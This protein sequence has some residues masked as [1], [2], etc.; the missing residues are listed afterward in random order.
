M[1]SVRIT[2]QTSLLRVEWVKGGREPR[3]LFEKWNSFSRI[4]VQR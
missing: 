1:N 3:P 4:T 2:E